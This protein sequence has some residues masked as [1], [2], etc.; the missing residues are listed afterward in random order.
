[1]AIRCFFHD[2][3]AIR[4]LMATGFGRHH[5]IIVYFLIGV[6]SDTPKGEIKTTVPAW[7]SGGDVQAVDAGCITP[8]KRFFL[9]Y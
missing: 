8:S 3:L 5:L 6:D 7:G 1:M 2:I 4:V 9:H